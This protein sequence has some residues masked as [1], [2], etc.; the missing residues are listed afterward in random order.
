MFPS[1][2]RFLLPRYQPHPSRRLPFPARRGRRCSSLP[3]PKP[4]NSRKK[5]T[6]PSM[7]M[8][9]AR[10]MSTRCALLVSVL[11]LAGCGRSMPNAPAPL[12]RS[13]TVGPPSSSQTPAPQ[14]DPPAE[15][16]GTVSDAHA[17]LE[18]APSR[19]AIASSPQTALRRYTL[20]YTNWRASGLP[21]RER[22]LALLAIG[23]ARLAAVVKIK[24]NSNRRLHQPTPRD[25]CLPCPLHPQYRCRTC[26]YSQRRSPSPC[27]SSPNTHPPPGASSH[28]PS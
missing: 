18:N 21:A 28:P 15:R 25:N 9:S 17:L 22:Q 19:G 11:G 8:P 12:G 4:M 23:P 6:G 5:A 1:P 14:G 10:S 20:A 26:T 13:L 7:S 16:G 24:A 27:P 3:P 2:R